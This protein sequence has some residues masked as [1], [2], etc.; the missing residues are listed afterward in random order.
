[1]GKL[2]NGLIPAGTACPFLTNCKFKVHT[3]PDAD[4]GVKANTFS[5]AAARLHDMIDNTSPGFSATAKT[6]VEKEANQPG[7]PFGDDII[8]DDDDGYTD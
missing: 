1:M 8:I 3:C 7:N 2:V 4:N 5:C 6:L